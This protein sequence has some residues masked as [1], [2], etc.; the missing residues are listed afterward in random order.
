[1]KEL[2]CN[3]CLYSTDSLIS[4]SNRLVG[5]MKVLIPTGYIGE[6]CLNYDRGNPLK[7]NSITYNIFYRNQVCTVEYI[8]V[9]IAYLRRKCRWQRITKNKNTSLIRHIFTV[10]VYRNIVRYP[11]GQLVMIPQLSYHR[12]C[13]IEFPVTW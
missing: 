3:S 1:M 7:H 6:T 4:T 12:K 13:L 11:L 10:F 2:Y 9:I 5:L 8:H